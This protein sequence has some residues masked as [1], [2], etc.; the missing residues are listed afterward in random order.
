M[1]NKFKVGDTVRCVIGRFPEMSVGH[2]RKVVEVDGYLLCFYTDSD[3]W[4]HVRGFE[5]VL[6]PV[7]KPKFKV[8]DR[9]VVCWPSCHCYCCACVGVVTT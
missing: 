3:L 9:V 7:S 1:L 2:I 4:Y 8:G 6:P 5:L